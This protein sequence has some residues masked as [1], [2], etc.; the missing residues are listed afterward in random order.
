MRGLLALVL[1]PSILTAEPHLARA[2][3]A[4]FF[5]DSAQ[6]HIEPSGLSAAPPSPQP[7][8]E[9][10][11]LVKP[12][13]EHQV[14]AALNLGI[15]SAVGTLGMTFSF[16]PTRFLAT[17]IGLGLGSSGVQL[18]AMQKVVLGEGDTIRFLGGAGISYSDGGHDFPTSTLWLNV[19]L[20]TMEIRSR[21]GLVVFFGGGVTTALAGGTYRDPIQND[22]GK[23]YCGNAVGAVFPQGR[24]GVGV[25]F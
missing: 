3:S 14:T 8:T 13:S 17:E 12:W 20:A 2:Q 18:S 4:D 15:G 6:R 25:W 9:R 21:S 22:C 23:T 11:P 10:N 19:D 16:I 7:S 5:S 1:V 24:A